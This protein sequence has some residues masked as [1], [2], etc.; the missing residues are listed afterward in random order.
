[1]STPRSAGSLTPARRIRGSCSFP[2][3]GDGGSTGTPRTRQSAGRTGVL[4]M[5]R[6]AT[7]GFTAV[8]LIADLIEWPRAA[9]QRFGYR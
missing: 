8:Y 5:V 9:S 2:A 6:L 7:V 1:M 3:D 4:L